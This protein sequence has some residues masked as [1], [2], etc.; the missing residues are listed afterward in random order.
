MIE[1]TFFDDVGEAVVL[2][3]STFGGPRN[4]FGTK[5]RKNASMALPAL[6]VRRSPRAASRPVVRDRQRMGRLIV[7][8]S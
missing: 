4:S 6:Q 3:L 2:P 8:G 5:R 1:T 7:L